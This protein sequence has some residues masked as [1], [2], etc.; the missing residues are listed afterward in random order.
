MSSELEKEKQRQ[1][2]EA[3]RRREEEE[4]RRQVR[5]KYEEAQRRAR[6]ESE[7]GRDIA[8]Q[9][10]EEG[11]KLGEE[12]ARRA[13]EESQ[14]KLR[15]PTYLQTIP[16]DTGGSSKGGSTP[17]SSPALPLTTIASPPPRVY[18]AII[19]CGTAAVVNH[20]TLRQTK[21]GTEQRI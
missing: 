20:T 4:M 15:T 17:V 5:E 7:R 3:R 11:S 2:E 9:S 6:E 18:Y 8:R 1:E 12:Q 14:L 16:S 10:V 13:H 19:G 21:W